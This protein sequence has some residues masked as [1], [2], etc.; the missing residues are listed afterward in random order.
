MC[1]FR[2]MARSII[3]LQTDNHLV[4]VLREMVGGESSILPG[5]QE[6]LTEQLKRQIFV[7]PIL[8]IPAHTM[9]LKGCFGCVLGLGASPAF[10]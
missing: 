9:I 5:T 7:G 3:L 1:R 2:H 4:S 6:L 10:L 8:E